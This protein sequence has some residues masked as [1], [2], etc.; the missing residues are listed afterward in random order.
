VVVISALEAKVMGMVD[1][2]FS[3]TAWVMDV[4]DLR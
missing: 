3:L 1:A 2:G 4:G